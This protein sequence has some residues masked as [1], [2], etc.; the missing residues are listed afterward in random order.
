MNA[1]R[2]KW[3]TGVVFVALLTEAIVAGQQSRLKRRCANP[4]ACSPVGSTLLVYV[5]DNLGAV[6]SD[7]KVRVDPPVFQGP[8][9]KQLSGVIT[10]WYGMAAI[11]LKPETDYRID[12]SQ[13]GWLPVT[14][15][16]VRLAAGRVEA[17]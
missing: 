4:T 6:I 9:D 17:L 14:L 1:A 7:V 15:P 11:S 5:R 2:M 10:D 16:R 3:W 13:D 8:P 12:V